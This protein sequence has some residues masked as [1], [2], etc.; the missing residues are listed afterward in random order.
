MNE[1]ATLSQDQLMHEVEMVD[2]RA[3]YLKTEIGQTKAQKYVMEMLAYLSYSGYRPPES[4]R[5][6]MAAA[7]VDALREEIAIYGFDVLREAF[8]EFVKNDTREYRQWPNPGLII[9]EMKRTGHNPK[10]ELARRQKEKREAELEKKWQAEKA[11]RRKE[12]PADKRRKFRER[13][14]RIYGI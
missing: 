9:A 14:A 2:R 13:M 10:A 7:W 4:N 11:E 6:F 5:N 1:L 3:D 12:I 8:R